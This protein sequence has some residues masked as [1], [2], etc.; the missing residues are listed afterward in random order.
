MVLMIFPTS[1]DLKHK[2]GKA[3]YRTGKPKERQGSVVFPT[4]AKTNRFTELQARTYVRK[5]C[6][7]GYLYEPKPGYFKRA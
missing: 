6:D 7:F 4:D 5:A 3:I 2:L 1:Y